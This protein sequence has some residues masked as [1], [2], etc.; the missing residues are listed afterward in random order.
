MVEEGKAGATFEYVH[1]YVSDQV[2]VCRYM[3]THVNSWVCMSVYVRTYVVVCVVYV[4]M[5]ESESVFCALPC[6]RRSCSLRVLFPRWAGR[7]SPLRTRRLPE[8]HTRCRPVQ[9]VMQEPSLSKATAADSAAIQAY[10]TSKSFVPHRC[11]FFFFLEQNPSPYSARL[12]FLIAVLRQWIN[13]WRKCEENIITARWWRRR[14]N[15]WVGE[16]LIFF[17]CLPQRSSRG[18][19]QQGLQLH[20]QCSFRIHMRLCVPCAPA[21]QLRLLPVVVVPPQERKRERIQS[22]SQSVTWTKSLVWSN[23]RGLN[24]KQSRTSIRE[25]PNFVY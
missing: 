16:W 18:E 22:V 8:G 12:H 15:G 11:F 6:W 1:T 14:I 3:L 10:K 20:R 4:C 2:E 9:P 13:Q 24:N 21:S 23:L 17:P 25:T 19:A 7:S 5:Y